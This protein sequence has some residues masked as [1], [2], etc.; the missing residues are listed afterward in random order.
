MARVCQAA[1]LGTR[2]VGVRTEGLHEICFRLSAG[3]VPLVAA[4]ERLDELFLAPALPPQ[5][6][7]MLGKEDLAARA[8]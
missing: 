5:G 2:R 8:Q 4:R 3:R 6:F 1:E 7:K